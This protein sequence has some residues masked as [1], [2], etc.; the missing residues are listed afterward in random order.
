MFSVIITSRRGECESTTI[1]NFLHA[2]YWASFGKGFSASNCHIALN[3]VQKDHNLARH[4]YGVEVV[5]EWWE[6]R[7]PTLFLPTLRPVR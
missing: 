6:N 2:L 5:S 7:G 1:L 4:A 3:T